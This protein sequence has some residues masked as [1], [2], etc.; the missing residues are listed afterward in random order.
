MYIT[1]I[2]YIKAPEFCT[3]KQTHFLSFWTPHPC[4]PER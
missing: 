2:L 3:E 1:S 4:H